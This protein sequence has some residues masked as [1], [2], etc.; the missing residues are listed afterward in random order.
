MTYHPWLQRPVGVLV[1]AKPGSMEMR[2]GMTE[3]SWPLKRQNLGLSEQG[4][5]L[6]QRSKLAHLFLWEYS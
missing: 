2:S 6:G 1:L 4:V 5:R 3:T